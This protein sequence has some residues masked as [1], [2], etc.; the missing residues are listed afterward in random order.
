MRVNK[1][2]RK[3]CVALQSLSLRCLAKQTPQ[4]N[5]DVT[6][7]REIHVNSRS[8]V[9]LEEKDLVLVSSKKGQKG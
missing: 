4:T 6:H 7:V 9:D 5:V 8:R 2:Q 1:F 3:L